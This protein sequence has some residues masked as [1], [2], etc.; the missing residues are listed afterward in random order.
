MAWGSSA[1][2]ERREQRG[3]SRTKVPAFAVDIAL[4]VLLTLLMMRAQLPALFHQVAGIAFGALVMA[5]LW[6]HRAWLAALVRGRL[7][8]RSL[9]L[10]VAM[11][12][13]L[14][15]A[16]VLVASGLVMSTW[17][18]GLGIAAG[19]GVARSLHLPLSH[20]LYCL[21]GLHAGLS[22]HGAQRMPRPALAIWCAVAAMGVW[23][24]VTLGFPT[25]I[26]G[27][28]AFA[29]VDP[30]KPIPFTFV[31]Y[32]SVFALFALAGAVLQRITGK[33]VASRG[34]S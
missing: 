1:M 22:V 32:A 12:A 15:C 25:Y 20:V 6:Q 14:A 28:V 2:G 26:T 3:R 4:F 5:H 19:T 31:Q 16:V 23:S 33:K 34:R 8:G 13:I 27:S 17:A 9:G 21:I 10:A 18:T 11:A 30:S 24:F 7:S 29:L